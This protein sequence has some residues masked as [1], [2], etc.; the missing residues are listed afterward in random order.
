M[1]GGRWDATIK[2]QELL[3]YLGPFFGIKGS[4]VDASYSK[5]CVM[6]MARPPT[7]YHRSSSQNLPIPNSS[8]KLADGKIHSQNSPGT[9]CSHKLPHILGPSPYQIALPPD[10]L[11]CI[12]CVFSKEALCRSQCLWVAKPACPHFPYPSLDNSNESKRSCF[13][14]A[15]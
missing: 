7:G 9:S 4:H 15:T 5:L 12:H 10:R 8:P 3:F 13:C 11:L 6:M 1:A 2:K 14:I